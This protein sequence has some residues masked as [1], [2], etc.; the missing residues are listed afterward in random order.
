[1]ENSTH[2]SRSAPIFHGIPLPE[3]GWVVG[4]AAIIE[5]LSLPVPMP[6]QKVMVSLQRRNYETEEWKVKP[7][8]HLPDDHSGMSKWEALYKQL[9]FAWKYEGVHLLVYYFLV[10]R[11]R[12]EVLREIVSIEPTGQYSRRMWFLMEFMLGAPLPGKEDL[13]KKNYVPLLDSKEYFTI[14]GTNSSRHRVINNLLGNRAF[15]PMIRKTP[16]LVQYVQ[17]AISEKAKNLISQVREDTVHRAAAFLLLKDSKASFSIEGESPKS[18]RAA[19]WADA[20]RQSGTRQLSKQELERLQ[21]IVI[22]N[23]R[24]IHMGFRQIGGFIGEHDRNTGTP[25]P[26]HISARWEDLDK[27]ITGLLT[28]NKE[29]LAQDVDAVLVATVTSFGFVF[30]HPFQDGNGRI[31]RYLIHHVLA[32]KG[33]TPPGI[34]FPI[35]AAILENILHYQQVLESFSRRILPFIDWEETADHNVRVLNDTSPYYQFIDLSQQA[36]FLFK[37][38]EDTVERIMPAEIDWL[39]RY[40]TFKQ[41]IEERFDMPN[42]IISQLVRFL[43]QNDGTLSKRARGK[44]FSELTDEEVLDIENAFNEHMLP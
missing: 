9:V 33:Y 42:R 19:L 1:M 41:W 35:S 23:P 44:E 29:L 26:E 39:N 12:V 31:H 32:R 28:V 20:L 2:F 3:E 11:L 15:C 17:S 6:T 43:E 4:Y 10:K 24:F 37:C 25:I 14:G 7:N 5:R 13:A 18:R 40:Q 36:L 30:I 34:I 21:K 27:L 8:S 38:V 22:E 16:K